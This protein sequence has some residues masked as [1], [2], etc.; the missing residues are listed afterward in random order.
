[1]NAPRNTKY[2]YLD[3]QKI[4]GSLGA[5][6]RGVDLSQNVPDGGPC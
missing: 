4:A 2:R 3:V 5:D 6:V 1:M